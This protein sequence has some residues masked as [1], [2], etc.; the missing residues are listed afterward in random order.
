[1]AE[2]D[3]RND[4]A[5]ILRRALSKWEEEGGASAVIPHELHK[6]IPEM[7]NAELVHLRIRVIALENMMIAVLAEGSDRQRELARQMAECISPRPGHTQ[8]PLT[9]QAAKHMTDLVDRAVHFKT[10]QP[11]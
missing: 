4:A 10:A 9:I 2:F 1:M 5:S 8:H 11:R 6:D 3:T 7:S